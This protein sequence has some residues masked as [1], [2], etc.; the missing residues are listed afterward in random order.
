MRSNLDKLSQPSKEGEGS[1]DGMTVFVRVAKA[2]EIPPGSGRVVVVQGYPVA[3]FN[4]DGRFYAVSNVCLHRGG[5]V[6]EGEL[7]GTIVTCPRHGWG[8][9]WRA[10][11]TRDSTRTFERSSGRPTRSTVSW[12]FRMTWRILRRT[13]RARLRRSHRAFR[14]PWSWRSRATSQGR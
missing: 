9:D 11:S 2:G 1:A 7:E 13:G 12:S 6:G 10:A 14:S 8:Y 4:V 3:L 5:P